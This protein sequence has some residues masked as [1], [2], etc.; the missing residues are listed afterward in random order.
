MSCIILLFVSIYPDAKEAPFIDS[1]TFDAIT[2]NFISPVSTEPIVAEAV[3]LMYHNAS[4]EDA[5][6]CDYLEGLT[7]VVG[8]MW[9]SCP[10]DHTARAF[11]KAGRKVYRYHMTHAPTTPLWGGRW[12]KVNHGSELQ[13]IFGV[14]LVPSDE[15]EFTEEEAHMSL[16]TI[17]YWA[18]LAKTG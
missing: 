18:N 14:P 6:D 8:D 9:F 16:R 11:T 4:C 3:K 15:Y 1:A 12:T 5:P 7:R 17:K 10:A 13:F 2:Q